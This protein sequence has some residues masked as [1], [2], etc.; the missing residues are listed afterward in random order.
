MTHCDSS[1]ANNQERSH[2]DLPEGVPR[3][4]SYYVYLTA[5][6][7]LACQHC[8]LSPKFER[9]GGTGGHLD[10]DLFALAIE[11]GLP[12]GLSSVKLT[13]GEPL[14][15]PEFIK[16]VDLLKEKQL[17]LT[18]ETNGV[19]LTMSLA[20]YLKE[21]STLTHISISL[22][23]A[24]AETHDSFRGVKGSFDEAVQGIRYLVKV[25]YRPQVI[26]SIHD[27]NVEEIEALVR[28]A[29]IVGAGSVKFNLIQPTGRGERM[30]EQGQA[31]NIQRL[32]ELGKFVESDLQKHTPLPLHYSWPI[33][34]HS[35]RRLMNDGGNGTCDIFGILGILPSGQMA[36]C[37]IGVQIPELC[38]G[39]LGVDRVAEVWA[40][41]PVLL[42]LRD[43]IP[44]KLNGICRNCIF[45][46]RCLGSCVAQNYQTEGY[47][48]APFWFCHQVY[49][50]GL[51]PL[52][53]Q[54][55]PRESILPLAIS[56][57]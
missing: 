40:S 12:L 51:F 17:G 6:C 24:T 34:F 45:R 50:T 25:G 18:I 28:L 26:M 49:E 22:D 39:L 19:L 2:I 47:L 56:K 54:R 7:N 42:R 53:R 41:H 4:N 27:G 1:V 11:E 10:Y 43:L 33:A 31:L 37:G 23:G 15:H 8:W 20:R 52:S 29:E 46:D 38:F 36:L 9:N 13:G 14:L 44:A 32:I 21:R 5:G 16:M 57:K 3:L 48:T 30:T 35:L 55:K